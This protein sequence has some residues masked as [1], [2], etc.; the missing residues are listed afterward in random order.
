LLTPP[1]RCCLLPGQSANR[2]S[3]APIRGKEEHG[4]QLETFDM[5]SNLKLIAGR[6]RFLLALLLLL[7]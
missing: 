6:V 7:A 3:V 2:K 1:Q 5:F 4:R